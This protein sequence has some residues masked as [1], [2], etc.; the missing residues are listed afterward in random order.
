MKVQ[1]IFQNNA[2]RAKVQR[3]NVNMTGFGESAPQQTSPIDDKKANE[4][5]KSNFLANVSFAGHTKDI[6]VEENKT[7]EW[8]TRKVPIYINRGTSGERIIGYNKEEYIKNVIDN[9]YTAYSDHGSYSDKNLD[10]AIRKAITMSDDYEGGEIKKC[11]SFSVNEP[12]YYRGPAYRENAKVY[13]ADKGESVYKDTFKE[14]NYVV[15]PENSSIS[16]YD[17]RLAKEID[18]NSEWGIGGVD[19]LGWS[20]T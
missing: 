16:D 4:A 7:Y 14:Y 12:S 13:F 5:I 8:A 1:K 2:L 6:P 19:G 9:G 17:N 15:M 10:T 20:W 3:S 18:E 11:K